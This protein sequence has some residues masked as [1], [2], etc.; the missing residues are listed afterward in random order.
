LQHQHQHGASRNASYSSPSH[1]TFIGSDWIFAAARNN[2]KTKSGTG[3]LQFRTE[4]SETGI[5]MML[6]LSYAKQQQMAD[7]MPTYSASIAADV[8]ASSLP[9][10]G[11]AEAIAEMAEILPRCLEPQRQ[12][13]QQRQSTA[14]SDSSRWWSIFPNHLQQQ[15]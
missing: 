7:L 12:E 13:Q 10:A 1:A 8:R 14:S 15:Q 11:T 5:Q 9:P 4:M 2:K 3:M 6:M